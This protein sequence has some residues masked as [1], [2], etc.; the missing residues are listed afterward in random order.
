MLLKRHFFNSN[1]VNIFT[2]ASLRSING[3]TSV[4]P[5]YSLYIGD[6]L[7]EQNY[8][9]LHNTTI[10]RGELYAIMM[11]ITAAARY[12]NYEKIRLYSDSQTSIF[13]I[14][15][16]IFNWVPTEIDGA[17]FGKDGRPISNIDYIMS[18][19]YYILQCELHIEFYHVKG[20]MKINDY[21]DLQKAKHVFATSNRINDHID[22]QFIRQVVMGNDQVDRYTGMMLNMH[23]QD[24]IY[25]NKNKSLI[26]IGYAP[27]DT[28]QYKSLIGK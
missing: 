16:R 4:C 25:R 14:R 20:H 6:I 27:F 3:V 2:D 18:I 12:Q 15:D 17:L 8:D 5:G 21:N 1:S 10:N 9:I 23:I 24:M 22:D 7:I 26:S 19:I 13:A 11:G 28:E